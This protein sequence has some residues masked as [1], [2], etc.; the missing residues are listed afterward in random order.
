MGPLSQKPK[1][2]AKFMNTPE[3]LSVLISLYAPEV[4]MKNKKISNRQVLIDYASAE[5]GRFYF[6]FPSGL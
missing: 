2:P 6:V 3:F 1:S 5:A 4:A